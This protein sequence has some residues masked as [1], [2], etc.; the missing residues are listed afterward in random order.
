MNKNK[1]KYYGCTSETNAEAKIVEVWKKTDLNCYIC[2][3]GD[4]DKAIHCF[5]NWVN[6]IGVVIGVAFYVKV[7]GDWVL[8][9][10]KSVDDKGN[11]V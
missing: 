3:F 6:Y 8:V 5:R 9:A 2:Y 1:V 11:Y 4:Y 10:D 7:D